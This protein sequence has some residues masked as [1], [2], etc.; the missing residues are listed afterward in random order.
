MVL[1]CIFGSALIHA[2]IVSLGEYCKENTED[3]TTKVYLK[4]PEGERFFPDLS[5]VLDKPVFR[6][7]IALLQKSRSTLTSTLKATLCSLMEAH[8]KHYNDKLIK[9]AG[10]RLPGLVLS[11]PWESN[12]NIKELG[13]T[14]TAYIWIGCC[15]FIGLPCDMWQAEADLSDAH[16]SI[17]EK[18][19]NSLL[20][21][22]ETKHLN[23]ATPQAPG[24]PPPAAVANS[25]PPG[26]WRRGES[27]IAFLCPLTVCSKIAYNPDTHCLKLTM[28]S[29]PAGDSS[30]S[31]ISPPDPYQS[32]GL[33]VKEETI[34][35]DIL[36]PSDADGQIIA[37]MRHLNHSYVIVWKRKTDENAALEILPSYS[38]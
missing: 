35:F 15:K 17:F 13:D 5:I 2:R 3:G 19:Y 1:L 6:Q 9:K 12:H 4:T 24:I 34:T 33:E 36:V 37:H 11:Q 10:G 20:G 30:S 22:A 29:P 23:L 28:S 27:F 7:Q 14:S 26:F 31:S 18:L 25:P 16:L 8:A 38:Q 21:K 32:Y